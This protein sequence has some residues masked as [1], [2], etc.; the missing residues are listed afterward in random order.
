MAEHRERRKREGMSM[1]TIWLTRED[2]EGLSRF[3]AEHQIESK[4]DA[5]AKALRTTFEKEQQTAS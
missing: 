4:Q 2:N 3:M 1:A 5:I